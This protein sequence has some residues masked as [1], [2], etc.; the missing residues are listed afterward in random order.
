MRSVPSDPWKAD[1]N[2][3]FGMHTTFPCWHTEYGIISPTPSIKKDN[4]ILIRI[5]FL[6]FVVIL[7]HIYVKLQLIMLSVLHC[8]NISNLCRIILLS[9]WHINFSFVFM[10]YDVS[11]LFLSLLSF[12]FSFRVKDFFAPRYK[13]YLLSPAVHFIL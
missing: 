11:W 12:C 5:C 1:R 6:S 2:S 10:L 8:K 3:W 4:N 9:L 13:D 7:S